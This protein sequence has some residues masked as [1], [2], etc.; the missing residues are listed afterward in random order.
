MI[1][2]A[3]ELPKNIAYLSIEIK[4]KKIITTN[5]HNRPGKGK[6]PS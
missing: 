1:S 6:A 2:Q 5:N 3:G 4:N